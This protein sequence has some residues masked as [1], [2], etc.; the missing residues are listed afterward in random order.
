MALAMRSRPTDANDDE[1]RLQRVNDRG[2]P[3]T[4]GD[5][6]RHNGEGHQPTTMGLANDAN[7]DKRMPT[8][9]RML[10]ATD[11]ANDYEGPPLTTGGRER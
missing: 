3:M 10:T 4:T 7:D 8:M 1:R 5:Y 2:P 6:Q 11:A 9:G